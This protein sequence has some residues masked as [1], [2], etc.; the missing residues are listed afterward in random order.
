M[1]STH[2]PTSHR[3]PR[4]H[5]RT[6]RIVVVIA[7]V[8]V[9]IAGGTV[10]AIAAL[11][12]GKA[13]ATTSLDTAQPHSTGATASTATPSPSAT[14][15]TRSPT[16]TDL[17]AAAFASCRT[18]IT[19]AEAAVAAA[20][21][22]ASH[23]AIHTQARTDFLAHR[24]T[25]AQTN[26]EFKKTKLLGPDDQ[27][28]FADAVTA[29]ERVANGCHGLATSAQ[30]AAKTCATKAAALQETV[31]AGQAVMRDWASHLHNMALHAEDEM[32]ATQARAAW[33]AAWKSAPANLDAFRAADAASTK[34]PSC[35]AG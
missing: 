12:G 27:S 1:T 29:Y 23:W 20:R 25:L 31:T 3:G 5:R 28:A 14:A 7:I 24:I 19:A 17:S 8:A 11:R 9:V 22:G 18:T 21:T 4:R 15:S 35:P 16:P 26:A 33:I 2:T 6:G 32:S 10:A 30:P 13:G 34:T